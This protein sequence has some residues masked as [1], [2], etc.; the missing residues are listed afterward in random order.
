MAKPS[1][2]TARTLTRLFPGTV[3]RKFDPLSDCVNADNKRKKKAAVPQHRGRPKI[4]PVVYLSKNPKIIPKG[5]SRELLRKQGRIQDV[6]LF[7]YMSCSEVKESILEVFPNFS[8]EFIYL[9]GH[10]DNTLS[11]YS[12]RDLDGNGAL[13]LAR[14]GSLYLLENAVNSGQPAVN[15]GQSAANSGQSAINSESTSGSSLRS[16]LLSNPGPSTSTCEERRSI[17]V[18]KADRAFEK[19]KVQY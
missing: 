18:E 9:Q 3:K 15:S 6:P 1:N 13:A 17:L 11:V 19:L 16:L 14:H 7:R 2:A 8:K 10:K 12:E 5:N 4:V